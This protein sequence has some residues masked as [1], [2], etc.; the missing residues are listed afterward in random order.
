LRLPHH[1]SQAF[2]D[3]VQRRMGIAACCAQSLEMRNDSAR[4]VDRQLLGNREM[5][6]QVQE[7]IDIAVLG[8]VIAVGIQR[9]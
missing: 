4:L 1:F 6:R 8:P 2:D 3:V 5:Q 9:R 7:R